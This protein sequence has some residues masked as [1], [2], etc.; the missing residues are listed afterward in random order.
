MRS[1]NVYEDKS[2]GIFDEENED[3]DDDADYP[4]TESRV[5][6]WGMYLR[7]HIRRQLSF[8]SCSMPL[9]DLDLQSVY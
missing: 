3:I 2:L 4:A 1:T 5:A 8:G 7:R 6:I 9:S